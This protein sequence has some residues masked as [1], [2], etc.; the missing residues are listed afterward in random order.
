MSRGLTRMTGDQNICTA[1]PHLATQVRGL[2][3]NQLKPCGDLLYGTIV[4]RRGSAAV[5]SAP[6]KLGLIDEI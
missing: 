3:H 1:D 2:L 6:D 5:I 4:N